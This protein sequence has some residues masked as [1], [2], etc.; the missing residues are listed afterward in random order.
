MKPL[1]QR[2]TFPP[3]ISVAGPV[4]PATMSWPTRF[5]QS[6]HVIP[7]GQIPVIFGVLRPF[8]RSSLQHLDEIVESIIATSGT[9]E[10]LRVTTLRWWQGAYRS[11]RSFLV[12]SGRERAFLSGDTEA[13][14]SVLRAWVAAARARGVSHTGVRAYWR[15]L[16][17]LF[18][19]VCATDG[20]G[21]PLRL[22][23]KP[24]A[25]IREPRCLPRASAERVLTF[26]RHYPWLSS[27]AAARNVA[28]VGLMLLAGLRRGE[29]L[30]LRCEDVWLDE[31]VIRV[32]RGKGRDGGKDRSA[33]APPQLAVILQ[34]Y[35]RAR[36]AAKRASPFLLTQTRSDT[37]LTA[38]SVHTLF[39][40][41]SVRSG[42]R[43][44]PHALR[45]TYATLLRQGGVSDRVAMDLLGHSSLTM[46]QRYSH[47]FS[48]EHREAAA[49]VW[50]DEA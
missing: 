12:T 39:R 10:G 33:Y 3:T 43:V 49:R 9:T 17:S 7:E 23:P 8:Q 13:Q 34:E 4:R 15:G 6:S 29:V 48:G 2:S 35:L 14:G 38:S 27:F 24:R 30:R 26:V 19:R 20:S 21:N 1:E 5:S 31:G 44:S 22:L 41:I 45:H 47:V 50:L 32:V 16:L 40:V 25:S 42:I 28:V 11:F 37:P 46:L 18:E 36:R